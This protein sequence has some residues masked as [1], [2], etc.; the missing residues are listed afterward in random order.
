[1]ELEV[2]LVTSS[3]IHSNEWISVITIILISL[4]KFHL[5]EVLQT[6][7]MIDNQNNFNEQ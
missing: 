7:S 3:L 4:L 6:V 2:V 5:M 1:M